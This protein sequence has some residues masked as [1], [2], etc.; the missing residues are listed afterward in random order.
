M[1]CEGYESAATAPDAASLRLRSTS[2]KRRTAASSC[3]YVVSSVRIAREVSRSLTSPFVRRRSLF[4]GKTRDFGDDRSK[5]RKR[6]R[7]RSTDPDS[8]PGQPQTSAL[9]SKRQRVDTSGSAYG[10]VKCSRCSTFFQTKEEAINHLHKTHRVDDALLNS[11][12][13][14]GVTARDP[15]DGRGYRQF[16]EPSESDLA[17]VRDA[18]DSDPSWLDDVPAYMRNARPQPALAQPASSGVA[19]D[20]AAVPVDSDDDDEEMGVD[21]QAAML[22]SMRPAPTRTAPTRTASTRI[23]PSQTVMANDVRDVAL[24]QSEW[25]EYRCWIHLCDHW[26][27]DPEAL[28]DHIRD[29]HRV[30]VSRRH[31][32]VDVAVFSV[33]NVGYFPIRAW[34][35]HYGKY[36]VPLVWH[37][38]AV[39]QTEQMEFSVFDKIIMPRDCTIFST[40]N[41][42]A[43]SRLAARAEGTERGYFLQRVSLRTPTGL[44]L[45]W[46]IRYNDPAARY[47]EGRV[48]PPGS[49]D[50]DQLGAASS[51][52]PDSRA[53]GYRY[54]V[55]IVNPT[56]SNNR[57]PVGRG[58][59]TTQAPASSVRATKPRGTDAEPTSGVVERGDVAQRVVGGGSRSFVA[60]SGD[61]VR[62]K[63]GEMPGAGPANGFNKN[64]IKP[65]KY[66]RKLHGGVPWTPPPEVTGQLAEQKKDE[67]NGH[68]VPPPQVTGAAKKSNQLSRN[69]AGGT[70]A[71]PGSAPIPQRI[72][73]IKSAVLSISCIRGATGFPGRANLERLVVHGE[74][75]FRTDGILHANSRL[76]PWAGDTRIFDGRLWARLLARGDDWIGHRFNDKGSLTPRQEQLNQAMASSS[77]QHRGGA[78]QVVDGTEKQPES[79]E[80]GDIE[81]KDPSN[82]DEEESE[83]GD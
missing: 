54:T 70:T 64:G 31:E 37:G 8:D 24:T 66:D 35:N 25:I 61:S 62:K 1:P 38:V 53:I 50:L 11:W 80:D 52:N 15:T 73:D 32:G 48:I 21:M 71:G 42:P 59:L 58:P 28:K 76:C 81:I 44:S 20:V 63:R 74:R 82:S 72:T 17:A 57:A 30:N 19:Q 47:S 39:Q 69:L 33:P 67:R 4:E 2:P 77:W 78:R 34:Y 5:P 36:V 27:P 56:A 83:E 9:G 46:R 12:T 79:E 18:H 75:H 10:G 55:Q 68:H 23:A 22:A 26:E 40:S 13:R 7:A 60:E 3:E 41:R 16:H 45:C 51:V 29:D 49:P 43:W 6:R 14:P 65:L